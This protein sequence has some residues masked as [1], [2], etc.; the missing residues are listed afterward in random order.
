MSKYLEPGR[1]SGPEVSYFSQFWRLGWGES[2]IKVLQIQ[3][4]VCR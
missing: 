4:L 2:K 3:F 1:R